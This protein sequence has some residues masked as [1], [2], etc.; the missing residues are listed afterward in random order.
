[1][2]GPIISHTE[3]LTT[4]RLKIKN[5]LCR[6]VFGCEKKDNGGKNNSK[7]NK[8]SKSVEMKEQMWLHGHSSG[9]LLRNFIEI[10]TS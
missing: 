4:V 6:Q 1:V 8:S 7:N 9:R 2:A 5:A 10:S 3:E